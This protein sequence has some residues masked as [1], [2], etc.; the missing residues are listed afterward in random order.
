MV[1]S[2]AL[3]E[4]IFFCEDDNTKAALVEEGASP[5]SIYTRAELRTLCVQNRIAPLNCGKS[6]RSNA[7]SPGGSPSDT[8][9]RCIAKCAFG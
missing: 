2:E 1:F 7:R 4:T 5:W 8:N 3:G 6:M 9:P